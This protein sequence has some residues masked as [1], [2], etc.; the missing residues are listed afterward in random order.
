MKSRAELNKGIFPACILLVVCLFVSFLLALTNAVTMEARL[1]EKERQDNL[2]KLAIFPEATQ[3]DELEIADPEGDGSSI[4]DVVSAT[5][6][7]GTLL[8]YVVEATSRGY[9][10]QLPLYVGFNPEGEIVGVQV[11]A[12]D[13]TP[14]LGQHVHDE[15]F[16]SQLVGG[17]AQSMVV[18]GQGASSSDLPA[19]SIDAISGAT[20][21]SKAFATSANLAMTYFRNHIQEVH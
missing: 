16:Y 2:S 15:V 7:S 17:S 3:F 21:S 6:A 5:D 10:G 13:E 1:A 8:G 19:E 9:G 14:G 11:P 20:I 4:L 18:V 12:N